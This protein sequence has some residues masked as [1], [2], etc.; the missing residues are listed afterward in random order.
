[1]QYPKNREILKN[2]AYIGNMYDDDRLAEFLS[3]LEEKQN[4]LQNNENDKN[5]NEDKEDEK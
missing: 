3:K 5:N 2:T 1:M 4:E